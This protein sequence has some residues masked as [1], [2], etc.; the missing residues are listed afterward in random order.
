MS[1]SIFCSSEDVPSVVVWG[2]LDKQLP[3]RHAQLWHRMLVDS[4]LVVVPGAGHMPMLES[5][6]LVN[7]AIRRLLHRLDEEHRHSAA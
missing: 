3:L 1:V 7:D 6:R 5:P 4:E 2:A